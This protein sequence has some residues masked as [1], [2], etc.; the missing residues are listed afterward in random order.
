[1]AGGC[2]ALIGLAFLLIN[3]MPALLAQLKGPL[4]KL[5]VAFPQ[6]TLTEFIVLFVIYVALWLCHGTM[7]LFLA[8]SFGSTTVSLLR[9][10]IIFYVAWTGGFLVLFVPAGFGV[11]DTLLSRL[12]ATLVPLQLS[13][14]TVLSVLARLSG[15]IG[16]IIWLSVS[17]VSAQRA[18]F[19][20][21]RRH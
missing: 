4:G 8:R 13:Q 5:L 17:L 21:Q 16:E 19:L 11:R 10:V 18:R 15:L 2:A 20:P 9:Y 3:K 12:L 6:V 14:A 1:L 7:L